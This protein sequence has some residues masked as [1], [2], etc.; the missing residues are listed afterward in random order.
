MNS[1]SLE[2]IRQTIINSIYENDDDIKKLIDNGF[3]VNAKF[4][5]NETLL[6]IIVSNMKSHQQNLFNFILRQKININDQDDRGQT[7]LMKLIINN[8]STTNDVYELLKHGANVNIEDSLG[9]TAL[10]YAVK[11][12]N[13]EVIEVLVKFGASILHKNLKNLTAIQ[14]AIKM[15]DIDSVNFLLLNMDYLTRQE[16]DNHK[17]YVLKIKP[18]FEMD[19]KI[20][21]EI[22]QTII[23]QFHDKVGYMRIFDTVESIYRF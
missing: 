9:N 17:E 16:I 8:E 14:M 21:Q 22:C 2:N 11:Y 19:N 23:E 7:S 10:I 20:N 4:S 5:H 1:F 18:R 12:H 3:D 13:I 15:E 6:M